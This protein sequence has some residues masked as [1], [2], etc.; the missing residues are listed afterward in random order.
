MTLYVCINFFIKE[1][2]LQ[3]KFEGIRWVKKA[4]Y[5]QNKIKNN[6]V[7]WNQSNKFV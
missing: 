4:L 7:L 6:A 5:K 2:Q 3:L 1:D